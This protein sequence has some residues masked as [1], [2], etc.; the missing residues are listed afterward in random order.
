MEVGIGTDDYQ[1]SH[2]GDGTTMLHGVR[3]GIGFHWDQHRDF[4]Y[5]GEMLLR[6]EDDTRQWTINRLPVETYLESVISS[7]MSAT[8]SLE[9]LKAHAVISRSWLLRQM[10]VKRGDVTTAG[11]LQAVE[12]N[13]AGGK[14]ATVV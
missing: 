6:K 2:N 12:P 8:S 14:Q 11:T 10:G 4:R 1:P 5:E 9:L 3:I 7:E 13:D